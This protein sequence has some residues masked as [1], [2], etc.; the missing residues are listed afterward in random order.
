LELIQNFIACNE[1]RGG[2]EITPGGNLIETTVLNY[3]RN[4]KLMRF[5][6]YTEGKRIK[7]LMEKLNPSNSNVVNIIKEAYRDYFSAHGDTITEL[8]KESIGETIGRFSKIYNHDE[9][10][11]VKDTLL[12][13]TGRNDP[14]SFETLL[15][16]A[17][18]NH[19]NIQ[20]D[21]NALLMSGVEQPAK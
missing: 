17:R 7:K 5:S 2:L 11:A 8:T 20:A 14:D 4:F 10:I 6:R 1:Q 16:Q 19:D 15:C 12:E 3:T 9:L 18:T 13:T 21:V